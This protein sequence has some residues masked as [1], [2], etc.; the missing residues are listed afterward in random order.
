[1]SH[2]KY[3]DS[4]GVPWEGRSFQGNSWAGDDGSC[5]SALAELLTASAID[6]ELFVGA[7]KTERLLIPLLA[8]LGE[9]ELGPN[10]L[11]VEKSADLAIV[12]VQT[13]DGKTAIPA[14]TSVTQMQAWNPEARPVPVDARKIAL[15]CASEGHD[16]MV[17]DAAGKA[18][19]LRRP[20]LAALAQGLSWVKPERNSVVI[21]HTNAVAGEFDEIESVHL[22]D[23]DPSNKLTQAELQIQLGLR[24]GLTP[25]ALKQLLQ[26]FTERLQTEVFNQNVDSIVLKLVTV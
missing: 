7:L 6:L 21:D 17:V 1:M 22:F 12:A 8:S 2:D 23:G 19:V 10:G 24:P 3:H 11:L 16:R 20:A 26:S 14:F 18:V 13:P 25:E 4:A 15:A 9:G 5:P